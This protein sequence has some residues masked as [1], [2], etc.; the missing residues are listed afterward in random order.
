MR[1]QVGEQPVRSR[2]A[3]GELTDEGDPGVDEDPLAVVPDQ[4]PA[5]ARRLARVFH[6]P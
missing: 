4:Q 6:T 1:E 3:G 5:L 2:Y